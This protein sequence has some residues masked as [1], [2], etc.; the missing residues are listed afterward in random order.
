M[1]ALTSQGMLGHTEAQGLQPVVDVRFSHGKLE[2]CRG[3]KVMLVPGTLKNK[4]DVYIGPPGSICQGRG[5][6]GLPRRTQDSGQARHR[7]EVT[8]RFNSICVL[9]HTESTVDTGGW[10]ETGD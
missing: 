8:L 5:L 2:F 10:K 9:L 4:E 6:L 1:E 7:G 3:Q